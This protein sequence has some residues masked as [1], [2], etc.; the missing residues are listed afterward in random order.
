MTASVQQ[1]LTHEFTTAVVYVE[2]IQSDDLKIVLT[3]SNGVSLSNGAVMRISG[4]SVVASGTGSG[5]LVAA[6]MAW[7]FIHIE[8]VAR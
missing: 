1:N 8:P 5:L 7:L 4:Q 6:C 2:A 3:T